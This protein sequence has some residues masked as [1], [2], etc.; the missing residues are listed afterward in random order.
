[1]QAWMGQLYLLF[2]DGVEKTQRVKNGSLNYI[3]QYRGVVD[4][5]LEEPYDVIAVGVLLWLE[6]PI[7]E[8]SAVSLVDGLCFASYLISTCSGVP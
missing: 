2:R 1:M 4:Q 3:R 5:E 6:L 8:H 7:K